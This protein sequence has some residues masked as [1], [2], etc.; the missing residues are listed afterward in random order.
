MFRTIAYRC[1]DLGLDYLTVYAFSTENWKRTIKE[2]NAILRLLEEYLLEAIDK[3]IGEG[4]RLN[5]LGDL[6]PLPNRLKHLIAT[7]TEMSVGL[8]GFQ[9]NLCVNY[10][11]RDEIVRAAAKS[12]KTGA[13]LEECLDTAGIPDP[14]LLIRPGGE[15]RLSNFLLWQCAYTELY[16]CDTLWPDFGIG[17][18]DAALAWY[19][20]RER[21]FGR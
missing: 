14:E 9:V 2:I 17:E 11:G 16:F 19:N 13:P 7:A 10:G 6:T 15:Q 3:I 18:L 12:A 20:E 1:R 4:I 8:T 5:V 21:R